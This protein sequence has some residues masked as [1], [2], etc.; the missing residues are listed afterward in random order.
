M[1][2][3]CQLQQLLLAVRSSCR[4]A[5]QL[6][7][8]CAASLAAPQEGADDAL[9][10]RGPRPASACM[11][12]LAIG[13]ASCSNPHVMSMTSWYPLPRTM[14]GTR[15]VPRGCPA[16]SPPPPRPPAPHMRDGQRLRVSCCVGERKDHEAHGGP[17]RVCV[18]WVCV[19]VCAGGGGASGAQ[20][21]GG[22]QLWDVGASGCLRGRMM[23]CA[24]R[25]AQASLHALYG[26]PG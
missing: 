1:T 17:A 4:A 13:K 25:T 8:G 21:G 2:G 20:R 3:R 12:L 10:G 23:P 18:R 9:P 5:G 6:I 24:A 15:P 11:Q 7:M 22:A 19:C 14:S 26:R 16:A